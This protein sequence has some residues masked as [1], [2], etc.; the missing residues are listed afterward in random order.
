MQPIPA[1][2]RLTIGLIIMLTA[3]CAHRAAQPAAHSP[4]R[5]GVNWSFYYGYRNNPVTFMPELRKLGGNFTRIILF[6]NQLEPTKDRYDWTAV[7][8]F[9][10]QLQSPDE[11]MI[12]LFTT[13]T[14]AT[15]RAGDTIPSSPPKDPQEYYDF[16]HALVKR[17][18]GKVRYFQLVGEPGSQLFWDGTADELVAHVN[19]FYKAV[20][21]A[22]PTA[23]VALPG[24]DGL[25]D[26]AFFDKMLDENR[27]A[28][29]VFDLHLYSDPYTI[30]SRIS[31]FRERM[32]HYGY[33][34]PI[35]NTEYHG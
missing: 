9:V 12:L 21:D 15:R 25:Q 24:S 32:R 13:S 29:D 23:L 26:F 34:K 1:T 31:Y 19:L 17:C 8:A 33:E 2:A 14:W 16:V 4:A 3:G 5:F 22:D 7:D 11:G 27:G 10:N 6:W 20:K 30:R 18:N 28:F 35:I